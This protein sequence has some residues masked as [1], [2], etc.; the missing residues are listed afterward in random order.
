MKFA[1][2]G[3]DMR[4]A[5]LAELLAEDGHEVSVFALDKI[6]TA[7]A[8]QKASAG[9]A[10]IG[11]DCV[12]LPL[13]AMAGGHILNTPLSNTV[14]LPETVFNVL[15]PG[16]L[17]C[18]GRIDEWTDC[19]LRSRGLC[20]EDYYAREELM[21]LNAIATAEGAVQLIMEETSITL[22]GAKCLVIGYGR[23]GKLLSQRLR[24]LG[25][26]VT[27]S[28]RKHEDFAWIKAYG[29]E[30]VH[31][32]ELSGQLK[33]FDIVVNTVPA[34]VLNET[35]LRELKRGC[36]CLDLASKPGGL[37]FQAAS[38]L[39][40]KAVWALGLPGDVAPVSSGEMIRDTIYNILQ[41]QGKGQC[42]K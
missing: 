18:A 19:E 20:A 41:E 27:V 39:G 15:E 11:A 37:D 16:Q 38:R 22:C 12:V 30:S 17:I 2:I 10:V 24:S 28:A 31:T 13:P 29:Y 33:K 26:H 4:Q 9:E 36:L 7:G 35:R 1:V 32:D 21:V 34:C 23:I 42:R 8:E 40:V 5:K 6:Q 3:G 25:A 14:H